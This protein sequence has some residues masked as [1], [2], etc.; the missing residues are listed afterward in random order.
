MGD[1]PGTRRPFFSSPR[2]VTTANALL[3]RHYAGDWGA[4]MAREAAQNEAV[5]AI[6]GAGG[7]PGRCS[8]TSS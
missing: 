4:V 3:A 2:V 8:A 5:L 6:L 7:E 1:S